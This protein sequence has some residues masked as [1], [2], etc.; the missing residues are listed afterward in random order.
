MI[1]SIKKIYP[2]TQHL[3]C[4]FHIDL[5]LRKKLKG[6]LDNQ[7]EEFRYKFYTYRNSFCKELFEQRWNQLVN[8]YSAAVKYLSE[9]LYT[10]KES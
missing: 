3:L 9:T 4:I 8:Q 7:F 2:N 6:K 10:K 5:N 1:H